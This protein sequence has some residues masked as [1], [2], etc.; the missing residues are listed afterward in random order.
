M[1][2]GFRENLSTNAKLVDD[3]DALSSWAT[4][5]GL[6]CDDAKDCDPDKEDAEFIDI[7]E[8]LTE[9]IRSLI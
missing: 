7:L 4:G 9:D 1:E 6:V 2:D 8:H 5:K 3:L